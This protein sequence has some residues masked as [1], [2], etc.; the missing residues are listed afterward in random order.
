MTAPEG[1]GPQQSTDTAA[2][3]RLAAELRSAYESGARVRDLAVASH[4]AQSEVRRLLREA[5]VTLGGVPPRKAWAA[6][7]VQ[8]G[9]P[10]PESQPTVLVP[11][12]VSSAPALSPPAVVGQRRRVA[13][14]I[15]RVGLDTSFAVV[16][17]WRSAIAVPVATQELLTATGLSY[18]EL[19]G[20]ELTVVIRA[21]A[22]HDRDLDAADWE[23]PGRE[24]AGRHRTAPR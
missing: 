13:A 15:V 24:H 20:T 2:R 18:A 1:P 17:Q 16:P 5:G 8:S 4:R 3:T 12:P 23:C 9:E 22:L 10:V 11:A 19:P 6:E 14:R 21:D 7:R